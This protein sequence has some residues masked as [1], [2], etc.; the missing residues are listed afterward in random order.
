[1]RVACIAPAPFATVSGGYEYDRR[2]V[3]GLRAA[4]HAVEVIELAGRHPLVDEAARAAAGAAWDA[5]APGTRPVIDGL[6]L[7]AFRDRASAFAQHR[8]VGLIH[9][10]TALEMGRPEPDR[11]CLRAAEQLL[12]PLLARVIVTSAF[13]GDR[14]VADFGVTRERIAVVVPGTDD[15]P[16]S[17]GS[18]GT[19]CHILSVGT[20]VPRKG[21][22]VLLR[23]LARL[24]DLDWQLT[25][26]GSSGR[27]S[28]YA[29]SL[30]TLAAALGIAGRVRFTREV[31]GA[32]LKTLWERSDLFALATYWEG[33]GMALAEALKR[34]LPVAVT[35]GGA[36]A[37]L[38]PV[39]AG[40]VCRPGDH[41]ELSQALRR[42][43]S[44]PALRGRMAEG[45]SE[46]GAALPA[47]PAQVRTFADALA[48]EHAA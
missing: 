17:T 40:V 29:R 11:A 4:G 48:A 36:A 31:D 2:M 21:H 39:E 32:A 7:P 3:Q 12:M 1:M 22:D 8:P 6:A 44:D 10:P 42:L 46:A 35:A 19:A 14:L 38:V 43:I 5:L 34:G 33:Y 28:A 41:E 16:R 15:A 24:R 13:T 20:L 9:H 45:A 30:S 37:S 23:A 26:V 18:G 47:W 27:D 25:I